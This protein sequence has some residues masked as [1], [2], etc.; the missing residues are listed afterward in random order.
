M[1]VVVTLEYRFDVTPDG[2]VWARTTFD[3]A[4]W[5]RY[6]AVFDEVQVTARANPVERAEP[7]W[8]RVDGPGVCFHELPHYIGPWQYMKQSAA[9]TRALVSAVRP[10]DAVIL[11]V[12]SP[13]ADRL[14]PMLAEAGK[15]YGVE[16]VGDPWDVFGPGV[17][18][19]PLRPLLRHHFARQL[20]RQC[21]GAC[22]ASYVTQEALQRRY[23]P[24][25]GVPT[26]GV[27]TI[28]LRPEAFV[29][30]PR[31]D[32]PPPRRRR[33]VFVGTLEQLQKGPDVLLAA[34]AS[35]RARGLD[36][37]VSLIGDGR[38]RGWLEERAQRLGIAE[39]TRFTGTLPSGAPIRRELDAA[40]LF[41]LP[42]R[43][44]G[45][46]RA[47]IEAMAR[48]LPCIGTGVGGI[49]ELIPAE[50]RVPVGDAEALAAKIAEF[51]G[52]PARMVVTSTRNLGRAREY[53]AEL[54][55]ERRTRF[56]R[57]LRRSTD[58]WLGA[59]WAA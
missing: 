56:Y 49:P 18:S 45:L 50:D 48:A 43:G 39:F 57:A 40:D 46:P 58:A 54:L 35:C 2:A 11:R 55:E 28:E 5:R 14:Q 36:V 13:I 23:P 59:R 4:F 3:H 53:R 24:A 33:L 47:M 25:R 37:E 19:H 15:P 41:V 38:M 34:V 10:G 20:K 27:S 7:G 32:R 31:R 29:A 51:L 30:E 42:T 9:L 26:F 6:L 8:M 21:A 22:A 52:D 1:R 16:V 12:G 44:E 17:F